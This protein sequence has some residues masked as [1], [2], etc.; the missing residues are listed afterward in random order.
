MP[1]PAISSCL[2]AGLTLTAATAIVLAPLAIPQGHP[3][4]T[5]PEVAVSDVRPTVSPANIEAF[6]ASVQA[7]L[8]DATTT[9]QGVAG[10]PGQT[11]IGLVN[12][13]ILTLIDDVFTGLIDATDDPTLVDS[14]TILKTLTYDAFVMLGVNL[15]RINP[16]VT[17]TTG[18]VGELLTSALTGSLQNIGIAVANVVNDPL[19]PA[20]Y[21]GLLTAGVAS[22]QLLA[23]NGLEAIQRLGDGGFEIAGIALDEVTFQFNNAV[24]GLSALATQLGNA[25]GNSVIEAVIAAVRSLAVAPAV[26]VFNL[27]SSTIGTVLATANAG[28][29]LVLDGATS[30]VNPTVNALEPTTTSLAASPLDPA[31]AKSTVAAHVPTRS[32]TLTTGQPGAQSDDVVPVVEQAL[33]KDAASEEDATA[34]E[35]A[36]PDTQSDDD[37]TDD[38]A[39]RPV[40]TGLRPHRPGPN[41]DSAQRNPTSNGAVQAP[42][43]DNKRD[44]DNRSPTDH[45]AAPRQSS[46]GDTDTRGGSEGNE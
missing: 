26:A 36:G 29:D 2:N 10:I 45:A 25:S 13:N 18:Q 46:G 21:A 41:D 33:D 20:S 44:S 22:G 7:V 16:V 37:S 27:G 6:I 42:T 8:D 19:S 34:A 9:V 23:G 5:I 14:L 31:V 32:F 39:S 12:N 38:S 4:V 1:Q 40:A 43:T 24:S 15:G 3:S 28:F 17:A 35:D 11:L 30:V